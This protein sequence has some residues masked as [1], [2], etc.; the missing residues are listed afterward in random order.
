[1][2]ED[3]EGLPEI[4]L[5]L[6]DDEPMLVDE[7]SGEEAVYR[8]SREEAV[9]GHSGEEV[10]YRHSREEVVYGHGG[11]EAAYKYG[12][13]EVAHIHGGELAG[14]SNGYDMELHP[15]YNP[16]YPPV[17]TTIIYEYMVVA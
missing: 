10:A 9:Y 3:D 12:G 11:E 17:V 6:G 4:M 15:R 8:H 7:H 14:Y 16:G 5:D 2:E 1:M 13:E